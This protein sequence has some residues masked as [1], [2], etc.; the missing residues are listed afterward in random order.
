MSTAKRRNQQENRRCQLCGAMIP[1]W[2]SSFAKAAIGERLVR[3]TA[4]FNAKDFTAICNLFAPDLSYT[5]DD[6]LNGSR[7]RLCTN[8]RAALERP[9]LKLRYD[10]PSLA[11]PSCRAPDGSWS[12]VRYI[13]FS[14]RPNAAPK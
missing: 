2:H 14:T 9:S 13:A 7:D 4:A 5:I 11:L 3:W 10:E 6:V 12:I 1:R 8:L